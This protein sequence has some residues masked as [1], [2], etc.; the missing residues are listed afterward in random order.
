[1]KMELNV[2]FVEDDQDDLRQ[3]SE[4]IETTITKNNLTVKINSINDF[5]S[6]IKEAN[7]PHIRYDLIVTD[8]YKGEHKSKD[9]A[10]LQ[11][12]KDYRKGKF[13]PIIVCSSGEK[14]AELE[15]TAFVN[16]ADKGV[17]GDID[18]KV[19]DILEIGLPQIIRSLNDEINSSA[20]NFLWSFLEKNWADLNKDQTLKKPVLER[21]I[22]KRTA[23]QIGD[24]E[25]GYSARINR[26]ALE[27]YIYPSF[28]HNYR[29]LGDIIQNKENDDDFR[30]ILT[31]HCHLYMHEGQS[32]PR[33]DYVLSVKTIEAEK[34]LGKQIET[35]DINK[36]K[37]WARSPAQT[38]GKPDGRH[39]YLPSF[40]NIP[41]LFCD[42]LQV[43]S[44]SYEIVES[45]YKSI[46]TLAQ[47]YAE[48]LQ[49][50]FTGFYSNVGIPEIETT[51]IENLLRKA[52]EE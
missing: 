52:K 25:A 1:M 35:A 21:L 26:H 6:G 46:A 18:K 43:E 8:T 39:W 28:E 20:G 23:I 51:S 7:N 33:A 9:A 32:K 37:L 34:V 11:I 22:K 16:W 49:Q 14:P 48:A 50:S 15:T 5:E 41:H 45:N 10:A 12:V 4:I 47:P 17:T 30:V 3:I 27:Y 24:I 38:K 40:M 13:C 19:H 44:L 31:P 36:L 29:S 2:L 42:F